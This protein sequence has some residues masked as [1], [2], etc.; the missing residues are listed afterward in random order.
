[1]LVTLSDE[2]LKQ[3]HNINNNRDFHTFIV[4]RE[5]SPIIRD[6]VLESFST[7]DAITLV[8]EYDNLSVD[9]Q[10]LLLEKIKV[11]LRERINAKITLKSTSNRNVRFNLAVGYCNG[12]LIVTF[13]PNQRPRNRSMFEKDDDNAEVV[14]A[15]KV[16]AVTV[17]DNKNQPTVAK[18]PKAVKAKS[19]KK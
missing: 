14:E 19:A 10:E 6:T 12:S 5:I 17:E 16:E 4:S 3:S 2:A 18:K 1:M 8:R 11:D 9:E 15:T 13:Y 7:P